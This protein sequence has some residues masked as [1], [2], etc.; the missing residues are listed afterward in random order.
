MTIRSQSLD[1]TRRGFEVIRLVCGSEGTTIECLK[2]VISYSSPVFDV[3]I[4]G[5]SVKNENNE[6]TLPEDR[7]VLIILLTE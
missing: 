3:A 5:S 1:S 2:Y 6:I 4:Y 7:S